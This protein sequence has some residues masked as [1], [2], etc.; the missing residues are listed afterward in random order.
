MTWFDAFLKQT[1]IDYGCYDALDILQNA[2]NQ[3]R[4]LH[5]DLW[6]K[7]KTFIDW[8]NSGPNCH[9]LKTELDKM[10]KD[11]F[12]SWSISVGSQNKLMNA[13]KK[14]VDHWAKTNQ[15]E[16]MN[17]VSKAYRGITFPTRLYSDEEI[18]EAWN[19]SHPKSDNPR[20]TRRTNPVGLNPFT[21]DG[22]Y[23]TAWDGNKL[24]GYSGFEDHGTWWALAGAR[25]HP[26]YANGGSK[27][28]TGIGSK[29]QK[30]KME[31]M[32]HKPGVGLLNNQ[33]IK[34]N[35]WVRS[36]IRKHWEVNPTELEKYYEHIPKKIVDFHKESA[37]QKGYDWV[38]YLPKIQQEIDAA[39]ENKRKE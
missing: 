22:D 8:V 36:F 27:G 21:F 37:E 10:H 35:G 15:K 33:T 3:D 2:V 31:K 7:H 12:N 23:L 13:V 6:L 1:K 11:G 29:L 26:D 39:W 32:A 20:V 14:A 19:E 25:V 4:E 24:I 38:I 5:D 28:F 30:E 17:S 9:M 16:F 18:V 34:G